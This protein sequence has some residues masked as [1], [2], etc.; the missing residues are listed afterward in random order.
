MTDIA[1]WLR[2]KQGTARA[3]PRE[4][5]PSTPEGPIRP[6]AFYLPQYHPIPENDAWWG[7]GFTEWTNVVRGTPRFVGHYQPHLPGELG[8]YDLRVPETRIAQAELAREHGVYGFCYYHYWFGGRRLLERPFREVVRSK[9]P[10]FPFCLCWA[11]ENWSRRWDGSEHQILIAQQHS[12][13]DDRALIEALF[14]AF[15]DERYIRVDGKPLFLVYRP[16]LLPNPAATADI[17]REA[18]VRAGIGD[19]YLCNV[20]SFDTVSPQVIGFDGAVEFPPNLKPM[21]RL[22]AE[23]SFVVPRFE[24]DVFE[25]EVPANPPAPPYPYYRGI[26]PAWDNTARRKDTATIV[27]GSTPE[28]YADWLEALCTYSRRHLPAD[29]RFIFINAWNEWGEGCHLEPDANS[30]RAYLEK[31]RAVLRHFQAPESSLAAGANVS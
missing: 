23:L 6:I 13:A 27:V 15:E 9:E 14:E 7:K 21:R 22:N 29:R 12:P 30:G 8:L 11:N 31:T 18:C 25:Y 16:M 5:V 3:L 1:S 28:K 4:D 20:H 24:G 2:T 19:L 26:F 17:W 10:D